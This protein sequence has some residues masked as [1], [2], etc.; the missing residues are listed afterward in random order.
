MAITDQIL[1]MGGGGYGNILS[2]VGNIAGS[3]GSI[4]KKIKSLSGKE[5]S[6][7]AIR[8]YNTNGFL[9]QNSL[10]IPEFFARAFDEPTYLSFRVEFMFNDPEMAIRNTAYN[11]QG[12]NDTAIRTAFYSQMY[13]YMPEPFLNDFFTRDGKGAMTPTDTSVGILYST[14]NYLDFNLG[15]HGRAMLLHTF[16]R[17]LKDIQ[18]NFPY[19]FT[20]L[21]GIDTL[22]SINAEEGIR[23][24]EGE[25][26]LECMEGID[27]KITQLLQLYRK[28]VWDDV[29]QRWALPDMMRFFGMRI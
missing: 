24:K 5:M 10:F 20:S 25:I 11:N 15:D 13:D 8:D 26:I 23:V 18:E 6:I 17:A 3:A 14:E 7:G 27:L 1:G 9:A 19:Y 22:T 12:I 29:Y 4:I 16:K 21:S 2:S 28:I